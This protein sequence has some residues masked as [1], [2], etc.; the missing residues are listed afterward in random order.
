MITAEH[1]ME[2]GRDV[3]AVPG[4]V[5]NPLSHVPLQLV[6]D[7]ATMIRGP[8]DLMHDLGIEPVGAQVAMRAELG[9][10]ERRILAQLRG[11][12]LPDR[13]ASALGVGLPEAVQ[14]LMR[15]ELRGF[16]R[17]VGGRYESTLR[18]RARRDEANE[19]ELVARVRT[20]SS[21]RARRVTRTSSSIG[22]ILSGHGRRRSGRCLND[23]HGVGTRG[24]PNHEADARQP[25][26]PPAD[27]ALIEGF[28]DHLALERHLA[29]S[30]STPT[31][32]TWRSSRP[33]WSAGRR[34]CPAR[35]S[36]T[37]AG[38]SPS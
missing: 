20:C 7:G 37:S 13:V 30:P 11:P 2:F 25:T 1:A 33:S 27:A 24:H 29:A 6:R 32:G 8:E 28:A 34:D 3:Y 38:S 18:A 26:L 4:A 17:N 14:L 36:T 21:R 10:G 16:V 31:A 19:P 12:T 35:G 9:D 5:T 22:G 15:L 23:P